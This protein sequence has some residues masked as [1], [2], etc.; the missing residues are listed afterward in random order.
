MI[1]RYTQNHHLSSPEEAQHLGNHHNFVLSIA[2]MESTLVGDVDAACKPWIPRTA[3]GLSTWLPTTITLQDL[4]S[5]AGK[6]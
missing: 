2:K 6:A 5:L 1:R 3:G 4:G